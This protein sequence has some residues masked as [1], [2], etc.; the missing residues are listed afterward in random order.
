MYKINKNFV[1]KE[2]ED[3]LLIIDITQNKNIY[4]FNSIGE[5]ILKNISKPKEEIIKMLIGKYN[6]KKNRLEKDY[7]KFVKLLLEANIIE[8]YNEE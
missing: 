7:N 8:V 1:L 6:V 2:S 3:C 4:Q 5:F